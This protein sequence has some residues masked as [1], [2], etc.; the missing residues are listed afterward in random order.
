MKSKILMLISLCLLTIGSALGQT[1]T[2][3]GIVTDERGDGVI[4]ATVRLKSDATVGT[5]TGM[6]GDFTLKAKQGEII[7][8]SYVGYKTQEVAAAPTLNIKL[9]PD[10]EMLDEVM[11]VAYGTAK[12]ESFTGSAAVVKTDAI[13][14]RTVSN[15]TKSLDGLVAGVQTTSGSGQPGSGS[16]IVIRGFG[17]ISASQAPLYVVDG[18]PYDG[19]LNALNP[20]DIESL[21]VIKD[22]SAGAL[23]GARGANGVIMVT[24]KKGKEGKVNVDLKVNL[25]ISQRAL[26]RYETL[27][28]HEWVQVALDQMRRFVIANKGV[29]PSDG[30]RVAMDELLNGSNKIFGNEQQYYP[31]TVSPD[32]LVDYNT[33][34]VDPNAG[35]KWDEDWL[36]T[37]MAKNPL[38]QDYQMT[39]S[40]GSEKTNYMFSLG[41]LEE[42]GLVRKTEFNRFSFR[43]NVDS[44]VNDWFNAG[45]NLSLVRSNS[46]GTSI[47]YGASATAYSNVFYSAMMQGPIYPVYIKD[48]NGENVKDSEGNDVYD[49]GPSRPSGALNGSNPIALLDLDKYG[50]I[51]DN[52]SGRTYARL[53]APETSVLSGLSFDV[54]F[55]FDYRL[56]KVKSYWNPKYGDGA[57]DSGSST[58]TD[59]HTISYTFNQLLTYRRGFGDHNF[60]VLAGHEFYRNEFQ[61]LSGTKSGFPFSGLYELNA[62]ATLKEALSFTDLYT[63]E[64]WLSR[65]NYNYADRYYLSLSYRRDGSSRFHEDVRW[66]DFWSAGASWR[67]SEEA[68]LQDVN[69]LN[70]L[71]LKASYGVQGNDNIGRLYAWQSLYDLGYSVG[72]K[73]GALISSLETK[74]LK[75]EKNANL[76]VGLEARM[77][78]RLSVSLEYYRRYTRDMLMNYPMAASLGF[79][80]FPKNIGNMLNSGIEFTLSGDIIRTRDFR[81]NATL[82]GSTVKNKILALADKP[83]IISG[84]FITRENE[85]INSFYLA[86]SAGI[87]PA[88]GEKLYWVWDTDDNGVKGEKYITNDAKK[89]TACRTIVGSRIPDIYG[90]INNSF[91][92]KGVDMSILTTY[93]IGGLLIDN[94]YRGFLYPGQLGAAVHKDILEA[95]QKPGDIA[96]FPEVNPLKKAN[97]QMTSDEL[98]DASYFAIKNIT[99]GYSL[100]SKW[101]RGFNIQNVRLSF[102]ADN[103]WLFAARRGLDPQYNFS[104]TNSYSYT[105]TRTFS[106]G[107]D[108]RF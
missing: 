41:Y 42:N 68:F 18:V 20:A 66:G 13:N 29:N 100:P 70:N 72:S 73:A 106:F 5:M 12:K 16:S 6:D 8:V 86:E 36:N 33:G 87:D 84:N 89:A 107:L 59:N 21:T 14:K 10:T 35:L 39:V 51:A 80:S 46:S 53:I 78:D 58:I 104:G 99:V 23:Y 45:M 77:F 43:T 40:G 30:Y 60:D 37:V 57:K 52:A 28:Q 65:L 108:V 103:L 22:A 56:N 101:L 1:I 85:A 75:W 64:S 102:T 95:W 3:K 61:R 7:I 44:K 71:T 90:S 81:W 11:V 26:P 96:R 69:W 91:T 55:G 62:A 2:V 38:R 83:E 82:M 92:Y 34:H 98:T 48:K 74:N 15:V 32:K 93:S 17:S 27:G 94:Q 97:R 50:N 105:P 31:F 9:V 4:G 76:N 24:T 25:G 19:A 54:N 49:F 79:D 67:I 47:S 88:T 63:I